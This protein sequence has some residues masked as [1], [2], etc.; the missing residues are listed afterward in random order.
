MD[1]QQDPWAALRHPA[2]PVAL[3]RDPATAGTAGTAAAN[4][5]VPVAVMHRMITAA[6]RA[7]G[8]AREP[9]SE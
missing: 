5:A 2:L 7:A 8:A 9:A 3:L 1:H 4:P 6:E